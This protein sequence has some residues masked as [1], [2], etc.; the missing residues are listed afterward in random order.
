MVFKIALPRV[1][2][3]EA[4]KCMSDPAVVFY[5]EKIAPGSQEYLKGANL[6]N[7]LRNIVEE[8]SKITITVDRLSMKPVT[9]LLPMPAP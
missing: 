3:G 6:N 9:S 1:E 5:V 4:E 2:N 8:C 7:Y